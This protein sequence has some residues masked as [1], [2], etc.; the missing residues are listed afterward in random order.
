MTI[1]LSLFRTS[2]D[3]MDEDTWN[4]RRSQLIS[5]MGLIE[6]DFGTVKELLYQTKMMQVDEKLGQVKAGTASEYLEPL[7]KL[8]ENCETR[9]KVATELRRLKLEGIRG[10]RESEGPL[11]ARLMTC[12]W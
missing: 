3:D 10:D 5:I 7:K 11:S 9:H 1:L 12:S 8:E 4:G 2:S 6:K